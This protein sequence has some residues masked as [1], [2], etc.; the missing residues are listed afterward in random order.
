MSETKNFKKI[1]YRRYWVKNQNGLCNALY[2]FYE[3]T[4]NESKKEVRQDLLNVPG[5]YPCEITIHE[6]MPDHKIF[7]DILFL[8]KP[9]AKR[10]K[11]VMNRLFSL[12]AKSKKQQKKC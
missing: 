10:V 6:R 8:K 2:H 3:A 5:T 4:D 7:L 11:R 1:S 12:F 9:F